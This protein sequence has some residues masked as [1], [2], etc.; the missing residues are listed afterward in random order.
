M[1]VRVSNRFDLLDDQ[2]AQAMHQPVESLV[3]R[4][5]NRAADSVAGLESFS[6]RI[7]RSVLL[8]GTRQPISTP[9]F[10]STIRRT[11]KYACRCLRLAPLRPVGSSVHETLRNGSR[12]AVSRPISMAR[13]MN[14]ARSSLAS[15]SAW[16]LRC[17]GLFPADSGG[18]HG[19]PAFVG[20]T[21]IPHL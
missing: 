13:S 5:A 14:Y 20:H 9:V 19:V 10:G 6:R 1:R 16:H 12:K 15:R 3:A 7:A 21:A 11:T 2:R 8:A 17:D 4:L 18:A